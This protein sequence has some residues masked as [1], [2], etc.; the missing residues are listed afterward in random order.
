MNDVARENKM[1]LT[2]GEGDITG[3]EG[4]HQNGLNYCYITKQF[5]DRGTLL[6][7]CT[8]PCAPRMHPMQQLR[9]L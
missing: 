7:C 9:L 3:L 2:F 8:T 6:M 4:R 1:G 5:L